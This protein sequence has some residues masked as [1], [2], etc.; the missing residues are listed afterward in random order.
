MKTGTFATVMFLVCSFVLA[1]SLLRAN[2][3]DWY[4]GRRGQW[5]QQHNAWQSVTATATITGSTGIAGD[6]TM[7]GFMVR[8]AAST[9]TVRPATIETTISSSN[10]NND[11]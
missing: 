5:I 9:T 8:T 7:D 6:G 1:P 4:Q 2:Q 10:R 3:D 11:K